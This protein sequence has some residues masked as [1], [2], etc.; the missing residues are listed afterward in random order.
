MSNVAQA[1]PALS[2]YLT[3]SSKTKLTHAASV[4]NTGGIRHQLYGRYSRVAPFYPINPFYFDCFLFSNCVFF[5]PYQ[6][7]VKRKRKLPSP[8]KV[9]G[10]QRQPDAAM[11]AWRA[12]LR[13]A[14]EPF[15]TDEKLIQ[16]QFRDHSLIRPEFEQAGKLLPPSR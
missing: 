6:P 12:S 14:P 5:S 8:A 9:Y 7:Q 4:I 11:E 1:Q 15:R 3:V 16:P 2:T 13:P 10:K